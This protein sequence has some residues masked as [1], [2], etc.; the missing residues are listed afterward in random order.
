MSLITP[1]SLHDNA[2]AHKDDGASFLFDEYANTFARLIADPKTDTP[3]VLGVHSKWGSGKTTLLK[4]LKAKLGR[5]AGLLQLPLER[6][7][8]HVR[9]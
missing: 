8:A 6:L 1:R 3:I 7:V 5:A 2:L 4:M 9:D